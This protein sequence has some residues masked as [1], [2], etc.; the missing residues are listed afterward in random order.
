[1]VALELKTVTYKRLCLSDTGLAEMK[2]KG[3]VFWA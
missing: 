3:V 1:M 2:V